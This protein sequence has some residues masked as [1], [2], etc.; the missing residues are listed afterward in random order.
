[1]K[2]FGFYALIL[3]SIPNFALADFDGT[4]SKVIDG[5]TVIVRTI[6]VRLVG[7]DAPELSQPYG[8]KSKRFLM[9]R[10]QGKRVTIQTQGEDRY[11]RTLGVVFLDGQN[12]NGQLLAEG[13]AWWSFRWSQDREFGLLELDAK[14]EKRGLW[15]SKKPVSPWIFRKLAKILQ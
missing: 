12:I 11:G 9:E 7:L 10:I 8:K 1:M 14:L 13:L 4:V 6:K 3:L 15:Q 2:I 5:D